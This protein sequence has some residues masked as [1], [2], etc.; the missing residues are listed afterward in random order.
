[1]RDASE[2]LRQLSVNVGFLDCDQKLPE[3]GKTVFERF[4]IVQNKKAKDTTVFLTGN[5]QPPARV[6]AR[7]LEV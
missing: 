6:E 5:N 4:D 2:E 3:S 1:M 7:H